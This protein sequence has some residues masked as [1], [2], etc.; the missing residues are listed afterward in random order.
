MGEGS[1]VARTFMYRTVLPAP[2]KNLDF[3]QSKFSLVHPSSVKSNIIYPDV[4]KDSMVIVISPLSSPLSYMCH[5]FLQ[6]STILPTL[7]QATSQVSS[8]SHL[9]KPSH[10]PN[11][12]LQIHT[13]THTM[14]VVLSRRTSRVNRRPLTLL[15][16]GHISPCWHLH[17]YTVAAELV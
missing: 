7:I 1:L 5:E 15:N 12:A 14:Q 11:S 16:N 4:K 3:I 8:N 2:G 17:P 6:F 9:I 13:H 10:L